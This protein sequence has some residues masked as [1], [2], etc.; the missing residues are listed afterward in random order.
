MLRLA[1]ASPMRNSWYWPSGCATLHGD[2]FFPGRPGETTGGGVSFVSAMY[3][4]EA[5]GRGRDTVAQAKRICRGGAGRS[6][7]NGHDHRSRAPRRPSDSDSGDCLASSSGSRARSQGATRC[8]WPS[9]SCAR[10]RSVG[11]AC[12]DARRRAV[13]TLAHYIDTSALVKLVVAERETEALQAWFAEADRGPVSCDLARAELVRAVRR[14]APDRV[15]EAREVLDS[16]TLIETTTAIFEDA[17]LLDPTILRTLDAVHI[18]AA[19]VLGDDLE[20]MVT[21][22]DRMAEAARANGIAVVAP[23]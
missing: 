6:R 10:A 15:V 12:G 17:G 13:L 22:D 7:R 23:A 5:H 3:Y 19:L 16:V 8:C 9:V 11:H 1:T 2:A 4:N 20:A 18:A 14:A 21:Y